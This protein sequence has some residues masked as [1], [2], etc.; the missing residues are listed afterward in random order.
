MTNP[1]NGIAMFPVPDGTGVLQNVPSILCSHLLE[2]KSGMMI[3][4]VCA[5]PGNKTTHI[6]A[7]MDNQVFLL[8]I[9]LIIVGCR[10]F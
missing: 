5:A 9:T 7:L 10:K 8:L 6:A 4:D 3:L 1:V 2:P